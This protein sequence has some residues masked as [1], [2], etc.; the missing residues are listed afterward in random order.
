MFKNLKLKYKITN[1]KNIG[2]NI[3]N[4]KKEYIG[5][6]INTELIIAKATQLIK[7]LFLSSRIVLYTNSNTKIATIT[8]APIGP[9]S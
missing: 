8:K 4:E 3:P 2:K 7:F 6:K 5:E 1:E 9:K